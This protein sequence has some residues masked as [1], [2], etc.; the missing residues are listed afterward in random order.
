MHRTYE[1]DV[2]EFLCRGKNSIKLVFAPANAYFKEKQKQEELFVSIDTLK[3]ALH[4]RKSLYMSG[5][6]WSPRLTDAGI[7]KSI[8]LLTVDS[9]RIREVQILQEHSGGRVFV[10]PKAE[11]EGED[12][13]IICRVSAPDG[14]NFAFPVNRKSEIPNPQ[15]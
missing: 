8:Y 5:W 1:F 10:T 13:S 6:D 2:T 15:L 4:L 12:Y 9:P 11:A 3:G 7:W 14:D